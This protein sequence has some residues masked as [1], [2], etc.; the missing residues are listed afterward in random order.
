MPKETQVPSVGVAKCLSR[1][2][3]QIHFEPD[4]MIYAMAS[5]FFGSQCVDD[6][7]SNRQRARKGA[8]GRGKGGTQKVLPTVRHALNEAE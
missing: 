2:W 6:K 4:L 5:Q 1:T 3:Q 7:R 8:E